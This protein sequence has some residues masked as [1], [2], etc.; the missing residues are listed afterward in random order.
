MCMSFNKSIAKTGRKRAK[1]ELKKTEKKADGE[2]GNRSKSEIV[3]SEIVRNGRK[4][5]TYLVFLI[6][7]SAESCGTKRI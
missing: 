6:I 5:R 7:Y 2:F 1:S 4:N 3:R